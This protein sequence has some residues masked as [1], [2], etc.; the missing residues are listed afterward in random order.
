MNDPLYLHLMRQLERCPPAPILLGYSGGVDSHVLLVLLA[1][2]VREHAGFTLHAVHVH[3]GLNPKAD[4]WASHCARICSELDV[5]FTQKSV[6]I[7]RQPRQSLEA[8]ARELRYQELAACLPEGGYLLTAHHQDDQL[9]TLLL[10]LKRGSGPRG[11]A[12][13]PMRQPF[14]CGELLRPL[15]GISRSLIVDWAQQQRLVWIE[16]DSNLDTRFDRNFLRNE[17]VPRLQERWPGFAA[18]AGRSSQLCAEQEQLCEELAAQDLLAIGQDDGSLT[19]S[20]LAALSPLRRQNLLRHWLR[21]A[22]VTPGYE[23]LQRIWPEL[24]LARQDA[25]PELVVGAAT[26]RRYGDQLFLV[27]KGQD[28]PSEPVPL[29]LF[30]EPA[31]LLLGDGHELSWLGGRGVRLP[32]KAEAVSVRFGAPGGERLQIVGRAGSRPLKKLWQELGVPPWQR[33]RVP[34]IYYGEQLV[35]AVGCFVVAG[36]AAA[37]EQGVCFSYK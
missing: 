3:H 36:F 27:C 37:D 6:S 18:M 30:D 33:G 29:N 11:L 20:A 12:A 34:L 15:L 24:V 8:L 1:R 14:A 28:L 19:L 32:A 10:G 16:D 31:S 21:Q 26:L 25:S 17:I 2:F 13:M 5:P 7:N 23:L 4:E 9:E 35:A 22:G